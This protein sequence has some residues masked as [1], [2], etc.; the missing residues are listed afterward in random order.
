MRLPIRLLSNSLSDARCRLPSL[1]QS[2]VSVTGLLCPLV[3]RL[4]LCRSFGTRN[5]AAPRKMKSTKNASAPKS[6]CFM[7]CLCGLDP[8]GLGLGKRPAPFFLLG[9]GT[10]GCGGGTL[11]SR[12][13]SVALPRHSLR[14][15]DYTHRFA[16]LCIGNLLIVHALV[17]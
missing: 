16:P 5:L 10:F 12:I 6:P 15:L 3:L 11:G 8:I 9:V 1:M 7:F 14:R 13:F 4:S 2:N 17:C